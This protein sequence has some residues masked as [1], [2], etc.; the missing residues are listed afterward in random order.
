M[1]H[2]TPVICL[3]LLS[4]L[5]SLTAF[6]QQPSEYFSPLSAKE[7]SE[8]IER[9]KK[10]K[11]E[12]KYQDKLSQEYYDFFVSNTNKE[13]L[14]QLEKDHIVKDSLLLGRCEDI[15]KKIKRANNNYNLDSI[16]IYINRSFVPNAACY[17]EGT[18]MINLGLILLTENEHELAM[19]IG[20]EIAHQ[21]LL[22]SDQKMKST[23]KKFTSEDFLDELKSI[24]KSSYE[25]YSRFK[26]LMEGHSVE[27]S[28]HSRFKESEADSLG[29]AIITNAGFD[30]VTGAKL[31]L[32]LDLSDQWLIAKD[33][34]N[35]RNTFEPA[36]ISTAYFT[37]GSR[38]KGLSKIEIT[39][40]KTKLADSLKTHPD[41][42]LRYKALTG[43]DTKVEIECCEKFSS[44]GKSIQERALFEIIRNL[45]ETNN[46]TET[47]HFSLIALKSGYDANIYNRF[48]ALAFSRMYHQDRFMKRF[49][50]VNAQ[51]PPNS[52]LKELQDF[53]FA[54]KAAEID[55][56][57]LY[58][59]NKLEG[60][61][62]DDLFARMQYN[63]L[64]KNSGVAKPDSAEIKEYDQNKYAYIL[65]QIL[66]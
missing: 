36:A 30:A 59:L 22:H 16:R 11:A 19:A 65:K 17:G 14:L 27:T 7:Y 37:S 49:E 28:R 13:I 1:K 31:L 9:L 5:L 35:I 38:Y 48:I 53:L 8:E 26:K 66:K 41:C 25:K 50:S 58:Y 57:A 43:I 44:P 64:V 61:S 18:I 52:T 42:S 40:E 56:L 45:Y 12:K 39:A 54:I 4:L 24:N 62:E 15:I 33:L 23:I 47:I 60:K 32:K 46:L 10:F 55:L 3:L 63:L 21:L 6:T 34:Y 29:A 2:L 20:H 51:A